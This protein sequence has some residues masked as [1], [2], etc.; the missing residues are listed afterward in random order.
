[1]NTSQ[2]P[3]ED[4]QIDQMSL[5]CEMK[6]IFFSILNSISKMAL[7]NQNVIVKGGAMQY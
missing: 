4:D 1:M 7:S 2:Y 3:D 5:R 6:W